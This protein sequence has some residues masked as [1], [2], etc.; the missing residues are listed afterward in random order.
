MIM[1][2]T[3]LTAAMAITISSLTLAA[4]ERSRPEPAETPQP[5]ATPEEKVSI[6]RPEAEVVTIEAPL[7]PLET[8]I[9]FADGG[10]ELSDAAMAQLA[11]IIQSPQ[12]QAGGA[13]ILRGHTDSAGHD[14]VNLRVSRKRAQAVENYLVENGIARERIEV[15]A[16][17]EMRPLAPN[18]KLDGT[19][20]EEGRAA[21]RRVDLTIAVSGTQASAPA[22]PAAMAP[23]AETPRPQ[24][25]AATLVEAI[26]APD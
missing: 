4:C 5:A 25:G 18:A 11:E 20:D 6:F 7:A 14:A 16:L 3:K 2:R 22:A 15:I 21:N 1:T 12:M 26:T 13:V 10:T 19:A 17:G 9:S 24:A 23:A 8:N